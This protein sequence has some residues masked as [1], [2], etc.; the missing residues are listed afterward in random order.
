MKKLFFLSLTLIP[1]LLF[2]QQYVFKR[3]TSVDG[4]EQNTIRALAQDN[5]GRLWIGL[6]EGFSIYDGNEFVNYTKKFGQ[7]GTAIGCFFQPSPDTM[8]A[9]VLYAGIAI[10]CKPAL[11]ADT[12]VRNIKGKKYFINNSIG[13]IFRDSKGRIWFCT[14]DGITRWSN[15]DPD[16]CSIR[17]FNK[18]N[19]PG[20]IIVYSGCED[21][22]GN[23]WFGTLK[24]LYKF[25]DDKFTLIRG[26]PKP[27]WY[28]L[29][30]GKDTI[31]AGTN[32][33][34]YLF[35]D[36]KFKRPFRN[37]P[38]YSTE[39]N[40]LFKD[41]DSNLWISSKE[42]V[43]LF[44]GKNLTNFSGS[45]GA[46]S[47]FVFTFFKDSFNNAWIGAV[48]GLY[49]MMNKNFS[50][51]DARF[52]YNYL[53]DLF[54]RKDG[55]IYVTTEDGLFEIKNNKLVYSPLNKILHT[56][57]V[58]IVLEDNN[59]KWIGTAEG[60]IKLKTG[61]KKVFTKKDGFDS[62]YITCIT[63]GGKDT[64]W[65][66]T[67]GYG[68]AGKGKVYLVIN[69]KVIEPVIL[70]TLRP[71]PVTVVYRDRKK[72]IWIGF[73]SAGL[74]K[75]SN[76]TLTRIRSKNSPVIKNIRNIFEDRDG[77][78][79]IMTRFSGVIKYTNGNFTNYNKKDGLTSNWV[80]GAIQDNK[81]TLWF[82][83]AAGVCSFDGKRFHKLIYGGE[84]L[85]GEIW[86]ETMDKMGNLWFANNNYIFK[87]NPGQEGAKH[88][89]YIYI[90]ELLV[91]DKSVNAKAGKSFL[92]DYDNNSVEI[93]FDDVNFGNVNSV[94]YQYKL[95]GLNTKWSNLAKRKY[96]VFNQLPP[97]KYQFLVKA[98]FDDGTW[99]KTNSDISFK[100]KTPLWLRTWFIILA[101]LLTAAIISI[102]TALIYQ[103]RIRQII[104]IQNIRSRIASDLHD[105]IG[106]NLSTISIFSELA[107]L[108]LEKEP[109]NASEIITRIG[110]MAR[111][112]AN[113]MGDIVWV[114]N[115]E[116]DSLKDVIEKMKG[117]AFE[118]LTARKI[119]LKFNIEQN[120]PKTRL[121]MDVRRN[122]LMIFKE[123]INNIAKHS[124]ASAVSIEL[125][126][127][128]D[129][130]TGYNI[131]M[132]IEDNG[133]GFDPLICDRGN[134]L[135]N[136]EKRSAEINAEIKITSVPGKGTIIKLQ[137]AVNR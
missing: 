122:L 90:K 63:K 53:F 93:S 104:R 118:L 96:V 9:S 124:N 26:S 29:P 57:I 51:I 131:I 66:S 14:N 80:I 17:H 114:I 47:K 22:R 71:N 69:D 25:S 111:E 95:A 133:K 130:R 81:G 87:Y 41:K 64:L 30:T 20:N 72:N 113:S 86:G 42:G 85:T 12:V 37:S 50:Y 136:L 13:N 128:K 2:S 106:A 102:I 83:T 56:K 110:K 8:W 5:I 68:E 79:W 73:F 105:D 99:S 76:N 84:L 44:D 77:N 23:L 78:I 119:E 116:T 100:I 10:I 45:Q 123:S 34:L 89:D 115:P 19:E 75:F 4:L 48:D 101:G 59:T 46:K 121:S 103:Y 31:W 135:N 24:G 137:K 55:L 97:G 58:R 120:L 3:Y 112:V 129:N 54:P 1:A 92:I 117:F 28:M 39:I 107:N 70:D 52:R 74:Y 38:L 21:D 125:I 108:K 6:A 33:G 11:G 35:T 60:L 88:S 98:K 43:F 61:T 82:C 132:Q 32:K 18:K 36:G 126:V 62:N 16:N 67:K 15:S 7:S 127:V 40:H 94:L 91:N 109:Q 27:I 65:V 134:G 49:K